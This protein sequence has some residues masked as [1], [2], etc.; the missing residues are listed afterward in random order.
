MVSRLM[1]YWNQ[2]NFEG[3]IQVADT[4]EADPRMVALADY[5]RKREAG[6]RKDAFRSLSVFLEQVKQLSDEEKDEI[7]DRILDLDFRHKSHQFLSQPIWNNLITPTLDRWKGNP[8]APA[9]ALFWDGFYR[10]NNEALRLVLAF[11]PEDHYV[12]TLLIDRICI[13]EVEY[14]VHH[15][16]N[17]TLLVELD[18]IEAWL[19]AGAELLI[20]CQDRQEC[21]QIEAEWRELRRLIDDWKEFKQST[22]SSFPAWCRENHRSHNR[23]GFQ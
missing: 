22:K 18:Q 20:A 9:R 17:N 14:A 19:S 16:E 5:C 12:R 21:A 8:N 4:L 3:L 10:R 15:I 2:D 7:V 23:Y 13:A 1:R 6:M 11:N